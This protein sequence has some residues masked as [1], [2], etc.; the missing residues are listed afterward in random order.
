MEHSFMEKEEILP[1]VAKMSL[2]MVISMLVNSLYNIVDSYFV[3]QISEQAISAL[4][5][6]F[7]LQNMIIAVGVGFGVGSN[8][9]V[10]IH[11]GQKDEKGATNTAAL[12][13]LLSVFNGIVLTAILIGTMRPF[14]Q[15]F[16]N[17][18]TV[19]EAGVQYG[20]IVFLFTT[21]VSMSINIEKLFQA[22]GKMRYA[23]MCMMIGCITNIVLD[24]IFIFGL[25][26]FPEMGIQGAA[27][28]TGIGQTVGF[29]IY[30]YLYYRGKLGLALRLTKD[31]FDL[32]IMKRIY[33]IGI[34][35]TLNISLSSVMLTLLN[36]ILASMSQ[37]GVLILGVYYK[38]QTFI[39]MPANG[40]IQ[41]I[42][43]LVGFNYG[44]KRFDRVQKIYHTSLLM[45][46]AMMGAGMMISLLFPEFLM[47]Q[48]T[49]NQETVVEG[50]KAM[51]IISF[52]F[53]VS[54]VSVTVSGCLEGVGKGMESFMIAVARFVAIMIP[55]AYLMAKIIGVNGVWYSF[56]ISETL[57]ALLAYWLYRKNFVVETR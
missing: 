43:P 40:I 15:S 32:S 16:T 18:M 10:A 28:A 53:I 34:P 19:I 17:D 29:L 48:F 52:G 11:L 33:A 25:G 37:T 27:I 20:T 12:S 39:Y 3:A 38:L 49:T 13:M 35:A 4:S 55:I 2:P 24:P 41:G 56:A 5:L 22:V 36:G 44:A 46:M 14:L 8:A 6:I 26:F 21:I 57:T 23:M 7:P 45:I 30:I 51:Q 42:R 1:L 9:V 54:S 47:S 31:A 50:A